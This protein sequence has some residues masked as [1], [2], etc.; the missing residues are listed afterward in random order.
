MS[1][2]GFTAEASLYKSQQ[3]VTAQFDWLC[4]VKCATALVSCIGTANPV[5]CLIDKG[6][7]EC[8]KCL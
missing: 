3:A 4:L 2:P 1:M 7:S 6:M 8:V 5:Q